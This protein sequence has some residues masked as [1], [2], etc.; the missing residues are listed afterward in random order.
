MS[1]PAPH[2]MAFPHALGTGL[3]IQSPL[4]PD[5]FAIDDSPSA[6]SSPARRGISNYDAIDILIDEYEQ[7]L[8]RFRRHSLVDEMR[9]AEHG[10]SF[11]FPDWAAP[12]FD[13]YD[14]LVYATDGA[15]DPCIGEDL[16]RLGY[17]A[18]YSFRLSPDALA[19]ADSGTGKR[20]GSGNL[21]GDAANDHRRPAKSPVAAETVSASPAAAN[22]WN[23]G[24][25]HG[26]A[27]WREDVE[28]RGPGGTTLVTHRS[29]ALDFGACG[30]GYLVDL[31][32]QRF[33]GEHTGIVLSQS[34]G[35]ANAA[36]G[37]T[38]V[39]QSG[40]AGSHYV[41]D[42]GGDL[43]VRSPD[44]PL[45]IALEDP[46][47]TENAVGTARVG[48]GAIC[49]S[50][51][52]RRHWEAAGHRL[53]HLLNAVDG[54]PANNVAATWVY[55]PMSTHT[56]AARP[57]STDFS[58]ALADGVA[59]ALF[60]TPANQLHKRLTEY[61]AARGSSQRAPHDSPS[62][63]ARATSSEPNAARAATPN[64][65]AFECAVLNSDRTV[66][67]STGFPGDFFI[68]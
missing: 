45:T 24:S 46:T 17:D 60:T 53:H 47:N 16:I 26:R 15:I 7:A 37:P 66:V 2:T 34:D 23:L 6:A 42:A 4:D 52:S 29:V 56:A 43:L 55:V 48:T 10:G 51:P 5:G 20:A 63:V 21:A 44:K 14:A 8:S 59:T 22:G 11:D 65:A 67:R 62:N 57:I 25:M 36:S 39:G 50:A 31:I 61:T 12:L 27:T 19:P 40:D 33:L 13:L 3:L 68:R 58:T 54:L 1:T 35:D 18:Q 49:A 30:K 64:Y 38:K 9:R 32:A 41:I 28:R